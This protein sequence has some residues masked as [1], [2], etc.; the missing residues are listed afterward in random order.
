MIVHAKVV[1]EMVNT[2]S[3]SRQD[4]KQ[5]ERD[6]RPSSCQA[7]RVRPRVVGNNHTN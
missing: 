3:E 5:L 2:K 6:K 4:L 7:K 1:L